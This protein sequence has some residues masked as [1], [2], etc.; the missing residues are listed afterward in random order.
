[1][2]TFLLK[3]FIFMKRPFLFLF[4]L[5]SFFAY[6][7][8]FAQSN[9]G[10]SVG[11]T[12]DG[13]RGHEQDLQKAIEFFHAGNQFLEQGEDML[14][15]RVSDVRYNAMAHSLIRKALEQFFKA[16]VYN[17]N[18]APLN[19][20]IG[21][22]YFYLNM[23]EDAIPFL[24]KADQLSTNKMSDV[25]F[26]LG[27]AYHLNSDFKTAIFHYDKAIKR[28]K[29]VYEIEKINSLIEQSHYARKVISDPLD[30][31]V[32]NMGAN[33]NTSAPEYLPISTDGDKAILFQRYVN[34]N[35][36]WYVAF[37]DGDNWTTAAPTGQ[38]F[39]LSAKE[40]FKVQTLVDNNRNPLTTRLFYVD[41]PFGKKDY[42]F[43][44]LVSVTPDGQ[45][46]YMTSSRNMY[47]APGN[48]SAIFETR[49]NPKGEWAV[50]AKSMGI[51][52]NPGMD[53]FGIVLSPDGNTIYFS[54]TGTE[55]IGGFDIYKS[56]R[57]GKDW[58]KPVNMGY[59][60]NSTGD[61]IVY[62]ISGDGQKL[63]I[64]SN[65]LGGYGDHDL[66]VVTLS[67]IQATPSITAQEP[68]VQYP[69]VLSGFV[70]DENTYMPLQ[71]V[72]V[73]IKDVETA[74]NRVFETDE[75]GMFQTTLISGTAYQIT[76]NEENYNPFAKEIT[77]AD[78]R[79]QK[80]SEYIKLTPASAI[81]AET[82]AEVSVS[83]LTGGETKREVPVHGILTDSETNQPLALVPIIVKN[84][85]TNTEE[86][87]R[88][89]NNGAYQIMLLE[90][91]PYLITIKK[92]NYESLQLD[93]IVADK[94]NSLEKD[95]VLK[96][97]QKTVIPPVTDTESAKSMGEGSRVDTVLV[98]SGE[99]YHPA[100]PVITTPAKT[101]K[102][103]PVKPAEKPKET[104]K[105]VETAPKPVEKPK[106]ATKPV[107]AT[108]KP[109]EKP[110]EAIKPVEATPK[111]VEKPAEATKPAETAPKPVEKPTE[112]VK[113]AETKP[114]K[115]EPRK[116][117]SRLLLT[118]YFDLDRANITDAEIVKV[119]QVI[120]QMKS[121]EHD[122]ELV[123]YTDEVGGNEY[124]RR[125][126]E[127][128]LDAV[129]T[130]LTMDGFAEDHITTV[131][132]YTPGNLEHTQI[133]RRK[134]NNRVEIWVK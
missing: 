28:L 101:K 74:E 63:Y 92:N 71:G 96:P 66:Y 38:R 85:N 90:E 98:D 97:A 127:R 111:P 81:T 58:S 67:Y 43:E 64:S 122:I 104:T 9:M 117:T 120:S 87:I 103:K 72:T 126:T 5:L 27:Q 132:N 41:Y 62:G 8:A 4:L 21:K 46:G 3:A 124:N 18:N 86:I 65:R 134:E 48:G 78:G 2:H 100:A 37:P 57:K 115:T 24:N 123:G 39:K 68:K 42:L 99:P 7:S 84:L 59:P 109:V 55:T 69:A 60:I 49:K 56:E 61:D 121:S 45:Y 108:P 80:V 105:P 79:G 129:I 20:A 33:V 113:P 36:D 17:P 11:F 14:K 25:D 118:I 94:D 50:R 93:V 47:D 23:P 53:E 75:T 107:E 32:E 12:R 26:M 16:N 40:F 6:T 44:T 19:Y 133:S 130:R 114:A 102:T 82:Q 89:D 30:I 1:L 119:A 106:E 54:S 29:D 35:N 77:L 88:T 116:Q 70:T 52:F 13:F 110:K 112:T 91:T 76:I 95:L 34:E 22:C 131:N 15:N 128:R 83:G 31:S 10:S 51:K 125:L 73:N